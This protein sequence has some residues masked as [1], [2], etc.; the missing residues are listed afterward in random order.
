MAVIPESNPCRH[1]PLPTEVEF[2]RIPELPGEI[3]L[4]QA[5]AVGAA[6]DAEPR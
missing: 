3:E 5:R 6:D 1:T 2:D 4:L